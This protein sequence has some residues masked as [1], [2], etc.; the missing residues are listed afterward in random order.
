MPASSQ[1]IIALPG[2]FLKLPLS[3][4]A[5]RGSHQLF[6]LIRLSSFWKKCE[7]MLISKSKNWGLLLEDKIKKFG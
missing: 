1:E 5:F 6:W 4:S 7:G 3:N 2:I